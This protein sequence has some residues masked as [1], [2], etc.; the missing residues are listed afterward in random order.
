MILQCFTFCEIYLDMLRPPTAA[1][2]A[3]SMCKKERF[4]SSGMCQ[5]SLHF[6]SLSIAQP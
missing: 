1:L 3:Y 6:S 2:E 5:F 4:V